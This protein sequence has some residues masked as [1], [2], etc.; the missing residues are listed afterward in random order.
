MLKAL[1]IQLRIL[2]AHGSLAICLGA[3]LLYLSAAMTNRLFEAIALVIAVLLAS[4]ALILG[5][6][7]DWVAA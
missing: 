7:A 4:T 1:N 5:A 3:A 2:L 6:L